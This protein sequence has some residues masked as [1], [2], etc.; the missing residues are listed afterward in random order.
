VG[1]GVGCW[2]YTSVKVGFRVYL[3]RDI[4]LRVSRNPVIRISVHIVGGG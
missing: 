3:S 1:V 2:G 4:L